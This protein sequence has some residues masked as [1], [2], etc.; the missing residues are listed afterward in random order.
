YD[1]ALRLADQ[2]VLDR[3]FTIEPAERVLRLSPRGMARLAELVQPLGGLWM[4]RLRREELARQAL[5]ARHLF[6][7]D[8]HYLVQDGKVQIVDEDT[9]RL[10]PDRSWE[11]GLHQLI[12]VKEGCQLS[13]RHETLARISYQ[14][15]FRRYLRLAGMTG[16]AREVAHEL[17]S[18]YR[19]PV[20]RVP[21]NRPLQRTG[22]GPRV[23]PDAETRWNAIVERI[24][25]LHRGGRPVLLGTRSVAASEHVSTLLDK[26]GLSHRVL[27]AR[28]DREEAQIVAEAGQPGQITVATNMAGRGTD[29]RLGDGVAGRGGLHRT[30][31]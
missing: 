22:L 12:E 2:L 18:V 27:N 11:Q 8:Q 31:A 29:I 5:V 3:D 1:T 25:D 20:V 21:T 10:M 26:A 30:A 13:S 15:F 28:Q 14:R 24:A 19:L 17:W 7:R 4:G 6:H 9:G 16:T 23:Y